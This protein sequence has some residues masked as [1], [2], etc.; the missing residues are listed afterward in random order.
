MP[1]FGKLYGLSTYVDPSLTE[2]GFIVFEAGTHSDAVKMTYG[3]WA[4][5]AE[6]KVAAFANNKLQYRESGCSAPV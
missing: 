5:L 4:R 3:D 1:P 2:D 6:P